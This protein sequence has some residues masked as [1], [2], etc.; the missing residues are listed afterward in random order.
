MKVALSEKYVGIASK[1]NNPDPFHHYLQVGLYKSDARMDY[2]MDVGMVSV[3]LLCYLPGLVQGSLLSIVCLRTLPNFC[4][5]YESVLC[6]TT[7]STSLSDSVPKGT[8]DVKIWSVMNTDECNTPH[9]TFNRRFDAMFGEDCRD[10]NGRLHHLRQGKV[11]INLVVSYL[12]K[13]NW[14]SVPLDLAEIKLQRLI[15]ELKLLQYVS[16]FCLLCPVINFIRRPD[17]L[18][19]VRPLNLTAKLKDA[20]NTS[21]PELS[22]QRK[23]VQ[24]FHSRQSQLEL[25]SQVFQPAETLPGPSSLTLDDSHSHTPNL[26]DITTTSNPNNK[27]PFSSINMDS[28]AA[29]DVDGQLAQRLSMHFFL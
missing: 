22:F 25:D 15:T 5:S 7:L 21:A 13:I 20:A 2:A 24:D 27:R 11:G 8:K 23:A 16:F 10:S 6:S 19:P 17:I 18:R 29:E 3:L 9:E 28:D 12:S 4:V 1:C 26:A 14:T